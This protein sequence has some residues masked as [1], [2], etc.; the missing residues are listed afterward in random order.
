MRTPAPGSDDP[1]AALSS[2]WHQVDG[3]DR[4]GSD[5]IS[6]I[7]FVDRG[8]Y[9]PS[10]FR[11]DLLA[12]AAVG[13]TTLAAA[14]LRQ[15]RGHAVHRM[16]VDVRHAQVAFRSERYL[17]V[18][19]GPPPPGWAPLS[20][21]YRTADERWV[22]LHCNFDHHRDGAASVLGVAPDRGL[23][24]EAVRRWAAADLEEA[25]AE[26]G[27]CASLM[28][29][30]AE[31]SEHPHARATSGL[32]VVE[33]TRVGD[34]PP[35]PLAPG[36]RAAGGVRV[37]D[38]S[39]VLAG[40]ICGRTLAAHGADVI[41]IGAADL[42]IVPLTVIDTGPG[43]LFAHLDLNRSADRERLRELVGESDVLVD[44]FRPGSLAARG[45]GMSDLHTLRPGLIHASLSAY[46]HLGPW[47]GRRGFDSL[48]QTATGIV[49]EGTTAAAGRSGESG[50]RTPVPLPA[51]ALDHGAGHL[52]AFGVMVALIR[53]SREGGSWMVR[54]SLL[55]VRD[56]LDSLGRD[57]SGVQVPDPEL[58]DVADLM[59]PLGGDFGPL[60]VVRPPGVI[61]GSE[62]RWDR[63]PARPGAHEPAFSPRAPTSRAS[64][65][66]RS[67]PA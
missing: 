2:L 31:W 12:A 3:D 15:E 41:R 37:L 35:E 43:K 5:L 19:G 30:P 38:M 28:R 33:V 4:L 27:M 44:G 16:E 39:R 7:E 29:S 22:Q 20:G 8:L 61:D 6:R 63:L 64:P 32:P 45:L 51:Q 65:P 46:S 47:S 42:P 53:R 67:G 11:V 24:E 60:T 36:D 1:A 17:R 62:P 18:D 55:Q 56:F 13:A 14:A 48:V 49:A 40:P 34:S 10:V 25:M 21:Y 23:F 52:L 9:L 66:P 58:D 26:A 50:A 57:S 54:T 59:M